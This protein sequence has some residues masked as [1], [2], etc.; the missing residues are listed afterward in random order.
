MRFITAKKI[1]T[2]DHCG[3]DINPGDKYQ[4]ESGNGPRYDDDDKQIGIEYW[5]SRL[6]FDSLKCIERMD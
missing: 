1:W 2:C 5:S 6:C 4:F 3:K